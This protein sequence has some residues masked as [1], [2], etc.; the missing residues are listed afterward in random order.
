MALRLAPHRGVGRVPCPPDRAAPQRSSLVGRV[1]RPEATGDL[2]E[3]AIDG[4]GGAAPGLG[5]GL[6]A[7]GEPPDFSMHELRNKIAWYQY[8][9]AKRPIFQVRPG[10]ENKWEIAFPD[11]LVQSVRE[12]LSETSE[13][14]Q[15]SP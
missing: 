7:V 11:E 13:P 2:A 12:K 6:A 5:S 8:D 3:F 9:N 15:A 1:E 14:E 4:A 10:M